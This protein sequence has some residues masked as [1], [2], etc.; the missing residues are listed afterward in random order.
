MIERVKKYIYSDHLCR[1]WM[2]YV[3][4]VKII[5]GIIHEHHFSKSQ[6]VGDELESISL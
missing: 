2:N 6:K 3:I 5:F 4:D 1:N